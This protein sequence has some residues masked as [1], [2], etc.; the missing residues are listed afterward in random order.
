MSTPVGFSDHN[1]IA[2]N[3]KAKVPKAKAIFGTYKRFFIKKNVKS[4]IEKI[5]GE[6]KN[7]DWKD[8][9]SDHNPGDSLD[10]CFYEYE[11]AFEHC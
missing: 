3:K 11:Y 5:V 9:Y 2:V 6:V 4:A 10:V 1:L 7:V 8:V